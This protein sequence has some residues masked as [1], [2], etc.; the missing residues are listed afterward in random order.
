MAKSFF[1]EKQRFEDK[2]ILAI[3]GLVGLFG[4]FGGIKSLLATD[5]NYTNTIFLF[6]IAAIAVA[7]IWWLTRLRMKVSISE[8]GI[9]FKLSPIHAKKRFIA[10]KDIAVCR[11]IKTSEA[12]RWSGKDINYK[13]E[14]KVSLTG[15]NGLA[16][17]T[18]DGQRYF[19]G[20]N[21]VNELQQA[22]DQFS[23]D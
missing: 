16:I 21:N 10:W 13:H 5:T 6:F 17:T 20:S 9:K 8:K 1:K 12:A 23:V 18:K 22:L 2:V 11:I 19:I 7:A 15:R 4:L 14:K 3:I